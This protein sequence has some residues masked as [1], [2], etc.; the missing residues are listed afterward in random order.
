MERKTHGG[1]CVNWHQ[2]GKTQ[3][4][5]LRNLFSEGP[6]FGKADAVIWSPGCL[7]FSIFQHFLIPHPSPIPKLWHWLWKLT[8]P[9][10]M[11]KGNIWGSC[12]QKVWGDLWLFLTAW[13]HTLFITSLFTP[14]S[15]LLTPSPWLWSPF[16]Y[17]TVLRAVKLAG[18]LYCR[19]LPFHLVA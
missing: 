15:A 17:P 11:T 7:T 8:L 10:K 13:D 12:R 16:G 1:T 2:E 9:K 3:R 14:R 4:S 18:F 19:V 5:P 6:H